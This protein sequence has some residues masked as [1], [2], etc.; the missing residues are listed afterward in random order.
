MEVNRCILVSED[1]TVGLSGRLNGESI[2][3]DC[4]WKG[5]RLVM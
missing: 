1:L 2:V 4:E 5:Y 3:S